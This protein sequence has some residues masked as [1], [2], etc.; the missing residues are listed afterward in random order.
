M[1]LARELRSFAALMSVLLNLHNCAGFVF[2]GKFSHRIS[3][4]RYH[5]L[6][7]S[8]E[9]IDNVTT[10]FAP[11]PGQGVDRAGLFRGGCHSS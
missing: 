6:S 3:T 5:L 8:N 2:F 11:S 10:L 1:I 9:E 7:T 4:K